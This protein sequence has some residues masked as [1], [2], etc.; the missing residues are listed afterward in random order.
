MSSTIDKKV[1]EALGYYKEYNSQKEK[2]LDL[3]KSKLEKLT[4]TFKNLTPNFNKFLVNVVYNLFAK[5]FHSYKCYN[6]SC[7]ISDTVLD[8]KDSSIPVVYVAN[9]VSLL[10]PAH[11]WTDFNQYGI[12]FPIFIAGANL[13]ANKGSKKLSYKIKNVFS[14]IANKVLTGINTSISSRRP[15][16]DHLEIK[17]SFL[18]SHFNHEGHLFYFPED[19]RSKDGSVGNFSRGYTSALLELFF[20]NPNQNILFVPVSIAYSK[21]PEDHYLSQK[22]KSGKS[23]RAQKV[24]LFTSFFNLQKNCE[25]SCTVFGDP[26]SL[27]EHFQDFD[28]STFDSKKTS[29]EFSTYLKERII[30]QMPF[31]TSY[32]WY[33]SIHDLG[34]DDK[35]FSQNQIE[36]DYGPKTTNLPVENIQSSASLDSF[37]KN[38]VKKDILIKDGHFFKIKNYEMIN[39]YNNKLSIYP[40]N[41]AV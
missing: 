6:H 8:L 17:K 40:S 22:N 36:N 41:E 38:L 24:N 4:L 30:D 28:Y 20:E 16:R 26:I 3:N 12:P 1:E 11:S 37:L 35:S 27:K 10:D 19:G 5:N 25:E 23:K 15:P 2:P 29:K 32:V 14:S 39:Y 18:K 33:S 7:K 21:V 31:Y 9:H 13:F 34:S